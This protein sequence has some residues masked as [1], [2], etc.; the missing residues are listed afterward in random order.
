MPEV[1]R[2][3]YPV[4]SAVIEELLADAQAKVDEISQRIGEGESISASAM[5]AIYTTAF[6]SLSMGLYSAVSDAVSA[7]IRKTIAAHRR[8]RRRAPEFPL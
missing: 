4:S 3:E 1:K 5:L 7:D 2:R 8:P 6:N